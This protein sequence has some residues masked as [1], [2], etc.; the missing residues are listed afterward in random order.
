MIDLTK[1]EG[2][3]PGPWSFRHKSDSMHAPSSTHPY[4]KA[5][6]RLVWDEY[7]MNEYP[8]EADI[9]LITD[10]PL[11]LVEVRRL[12]QDLH[13]TIRELQQYRTERDEILAT[14]RAITPHRRRWD[15]ICHYG[16]VPQSECAECMRISK[17]RDILEKYG[18]AHATA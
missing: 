10:A 1:Y 11:L 8:D 4:G 17:A 15:A 3:T 14:L 5:I 13:D 6:F 9:E 7:S 2:H 18:C 12:R 16:I